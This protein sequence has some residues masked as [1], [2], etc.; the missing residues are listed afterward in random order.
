MLTFSENPNFYI[1]SLE[2]P[3]EAIFAGGPFDRPDMRMR[4]QVLRETVQHFKNNYETIQAQVLNN[5]KNWHSEKAFGIE[6]IN[7]NAFVEVHSGD[8]GDVTAMLTKKF[9]HCFAVLNM[10]NAYVPGGAYI[11][12]AIAQEENMFR[13]TN[14]HFAVK[15]E[16]LISARRYN[17]LMIELISG[18]NG[19]VYLDREVP[20]ICVRG[21]EKR[22]LENL[23]Y[24]WLK[25][26]EIFP[27]YELR[28]AAMD[29]RNGQAFD[30]EQSKKIIRAQFDTLV[31]NN[32]Q[33]VV[34]GAHGCGAFLNPAEKVAENYKEVIAEY[35]N[36][37]QVIAFA[38]Y[39]AGYGPNNFDAFQNC[40]Q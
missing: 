30:N 16:Q 2:L 40:F 5:L 22:A 39:H 3:D 36:S 7:S 6:K 23:G 24:E 27:F 26:N 18:I 38:I 35:K 15:K 14:C 20:R 8:W 19:K 9:G 21:P 12:G 31:E 32:I 13:R 34:L 25:S 1:E 4:R 33:H 29:L 11:E 37:F 10:A 28:S 17:S